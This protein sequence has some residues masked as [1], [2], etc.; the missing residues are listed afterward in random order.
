MTIDWQDEHH[1]ATLTKC[2]IHR[3]HA[4]ELI[5]MSDAELADAVAKFGPHPDKTDRQIALVEAA[6]AEI[7]YRKSSGGER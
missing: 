7:A 3:D 1:I 4:R 5:S 2:G 6:K